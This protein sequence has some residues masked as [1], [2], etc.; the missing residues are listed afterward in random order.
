MN[1]EEFLKESGL[2]AAQFSRKFNIPQS[3]VYH[4]LKR[5]R[6]FSISLAEKIEK[7]TEGKVSWKE[8]LPIN[9]KLLPT[10]QK[11]KQHEKQE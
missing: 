11:E 1:F 3:T 4:L 9:Q 2:N 8:L 6:D 10:N 5:D 7:I